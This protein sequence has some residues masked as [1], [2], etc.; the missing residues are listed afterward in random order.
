MS[1]HLTGK[2]WQNAR[3]TQFRGRCTCGW[4][5]PFLRDVRTLAVADQIGHRR[6]AEPE[7]WIPQVDTSGGPTGDNSPEPGGNIGTES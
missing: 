3:G 2:P 5:A 6:A 1:K 4:E 7:A